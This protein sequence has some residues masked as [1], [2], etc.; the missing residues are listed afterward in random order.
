[1]LAHRPVLEGLHPR[2]RVRHHRLP[3]RC[4]G[5]C[6]FG[7]G[8]E[9]VDRAEPSVLANAS[10][11]WPSMSYVDAQFVKASLITTGKSIRWNQMTFRHIKM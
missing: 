1:M 10:F 8:G 2:P 4:D 9:G 11:G 7:A 3:L 6:A 5:V